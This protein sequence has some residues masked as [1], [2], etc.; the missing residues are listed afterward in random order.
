MA[1]ISS[2]LIN[3][4]GSAKHTGITDSRWSYLV[5]TDD[6]SMTPLEVIVG[7]HTGTPHAVPRLGDTMES[8]STCIDINAAP[9]Q[10][11]NYRR[12]IVTA[13]GGQPQ[14]GQTPGTDPVQTPPIERPVVWWMEYQTEQVAFAEDKAGSAV[15]N[16]AGQPFD[17]DPFVPRDLAVYV[18][19]KNYASIER[20]TELASNFTDTHNAALFWDNAIGT[21]KYLGTQSGEPVYEG[22]NAYYVGVSRFLMR[23]EGHTLRLQNRGWKYLDQVGGRLISAEDVDGSL[24]GEPYF[25]AADGT[26]LPDGDA[27]NYR[28]FETTLAADYSE[29]FAPDP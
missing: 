25:L 18:V 10:E 22:L 17:V 20:L 28:D 19:K 9:Q 1:V 24:P 4:T 5:E 16:S 12:W 27:I 29:F 23:P 14:P 8:N 6:K 15:T 7:S 2:K 3:R 13:I 26:K 11:L 21:V